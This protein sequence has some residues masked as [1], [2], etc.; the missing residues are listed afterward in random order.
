[1]DHGYK[2]DEIDE[3]QATLEDQARE[4]VIFA[5]VGQCSP[6]GAETHAG[7][8]VGWS[9]SEPQTN[10]SPLNLYGRGVY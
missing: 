4:P 1:M 3:C 9:P 5:E 2:S 10:F 6:D 8:I 7:H